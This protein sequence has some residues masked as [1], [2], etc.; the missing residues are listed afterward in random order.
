MG[1]KKKPL[2]THTP[3]PLSKVDRVI[4]LPGYMLSVSFH[5]PILSLGQHGS[6][7]LV[8]VAQ[9]VHVGKVAV[10]VVGPVLAQEVLER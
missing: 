6:D 1:I 7:L 10:V 9:E 4:N 3:D 2:Q 5:R 8:H